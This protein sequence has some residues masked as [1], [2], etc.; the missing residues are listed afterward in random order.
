MMLPIVILGD[1]FICSLNTAV[2]NTESEAAKKL[3]SSLSLKINVGE[4]ESTVIVILCVPAWYIFPT[5]SV[6]E[7]VIL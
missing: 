1:S 7:T 2:I 6:A 3:S 4:V 5:I